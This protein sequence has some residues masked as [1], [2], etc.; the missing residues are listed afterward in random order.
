MVVGGADRGGIIVRTERELDSLVEDQRLATGAVVKGLESHEGRLNYELVEG[1]GPISG[2][3]T[4]NLKGKDLV[5]QRPVIRQS[6]LA[7]EATKAEAEGSDKSTSD[8]EGGNTDSGSGSEMENNKLAIECKG[9]S[10]KDLEAMRRYEAKFGEAREGAQAGYCRKAFPWAQ[11]KHVVK[12]TPDEVIQAAKAFK[13]PPKQDK[14]RQRSYEYD[15]RGQ[16]VQLCERCFMPV[17]EFAYEGKSKDCFLHAECKAQSFIEEMKEDEAKLQAKQAEKKLKNRL[18]YEIGWRMENVPKNHQFAAAMGCSSAPNGLC[19]L[20]YD[21]TSRSVRVAATLEPAA[22]INLEYLILALKVRHQVQREPLFSLDPVDPKNLEETPQKKRYEPEWLANTSVGDVMFQADYFL[23]ELAL[24]EYTQPIAGMRSVFDWSELMERHHKPWAGRE[25][26]VV[27]KAVVHLAEDKTIVPFVKMGVEAREQVLGENGMEDAPVTSPDSPL[28]KFADTFTLNFDLI[29]ERKSV[30]FH[31]R[32]L[33]KASVVAKFLVDSGAKLDQSWLA[34]GDQIVDSTPPE[35][36]PEIPQLWNMR[37]LS[38]IQLKDGKIVDSE[39]GLGANLH[40]IYGGVQFGLDRF[41]L[42]QRSGAMP[43]S[44]MPGGVM[45]QPE[46]IHSMQLGPAGRPMFMPQRF[47]LSQ[48]GETPQGVDLNLDKFSLTEPERFAG[49]LPPCSAGEGSLEA[50]A[51]L[52]RAFL[53]RFREKRYSGLSK[54]H[55]SLL[56]SVFNP[57]MADRLEEGDAFIPPDPKIEYIT[58]LRNL[59]GEERLL[60][61]KRK[62]CFFDRSFVPGQAS[63]EFP[64]SWANQFQVDQPSQALKSRLVELQV[65]ENFQQSLVKDILPSAAPEFENAT[66]D[67]T[68]F[69]IYRLGSLEVR[70]VTEPGLSEVVGAVLSASTPAWNLQQSR[71]VSTLSSEDKIAKAKLYTEAIDSET[72]AR[73]DEKW[74]SRLNYCHWYVVLETEK[75]NVMV[76]EMLADGSTIMAVNPEGV[77]DRN[78]LA[79]VYM[80]IEDCRELNISYSSLKHAQTNNSKPM[81]EGVMPSKRNDYAAL[82]MSMMVKDAGAT[83]KN[84]GRTGR[85]PYPYT[86]YKSEGISSRRPYTTRKTGTSAIE[87]SPIAKKQEEY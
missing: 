32:E 76:T 12:E 29:A 3:I 62:S 54:D 41:E 58:K 42:A 10:P 25:W 34:M 45:H 75:G 23:K 59:V 46:G 33:A 36:F 63:M 83:Q 9:V 31:L 72:S 53:K 87:E 56:Q 8:T 79:K 35:K 68:L 84:N 39:T 52:G 21:E 18:E 17:G 70:T 28:K 11:P 37:G 73:L 86:G 69:R 82:V 15:S 65:D 4:M 19:C 78:S 44:L 60:L 67:G 38:R 6:M 48:R 7:V 13:E 80:V 47:Q 85:N 26:F 14:R 40:A 30:I 66:E 77:E 71:A 20:V 16:K 74:S 64:R 43:G 1:S 51:I 61:Q 49:T 55:Q 5:V 22:A 2:W 24:G 57:V 50:S 27:K 81:A